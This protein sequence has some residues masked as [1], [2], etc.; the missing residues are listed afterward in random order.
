MIGWSIPGGWTSCRFFSTDRLSAEIRF[1]VNLS[2]V[3]RALLTDW[4]RTREAISPTGAPTTLVAVARNARR[5]P[6]R[7]MAGEAGITGFTPDCASTATLAATG[8]GTWATRSS[9]RSALGV[10]GS[11]RRAG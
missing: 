6:A 1:R 11:S 7:S 8:R 3:S 5:A 10:G 2:A 9:I 4:D